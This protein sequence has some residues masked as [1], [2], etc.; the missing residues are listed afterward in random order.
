MSNEA[1]MQKLESLEQKIDDLEKTVKGGS[2]PGDNLS[3]TKGTAFAPYTEEIIEETK[4]GGKFDGLQVGSVESIL[5]KH[6]MKRRRKANL[7]FMRQISEEIPGFKFRKGNSTR[8]SELQ[9][10]KDSI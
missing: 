1:V 5:E 8:G 6:D 9:F 3:L 4:K 7:R 2:Q 10:H